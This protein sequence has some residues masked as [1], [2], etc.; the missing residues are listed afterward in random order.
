MSSLDMEGPYD[1]TSE[2]I[3]EVVT[4]TS[5]GNQCSWKYSEEWKI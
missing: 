5:P 1:F 4:K 3:D 2:K